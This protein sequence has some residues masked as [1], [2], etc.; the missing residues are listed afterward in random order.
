MAVPFVDAGALEQRLPIAE[1]IDTLEAAFRD[2]DPG[3]APSAPTSR[4]RPDR[5]C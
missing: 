3:A 1:A 5:S 2:G 4:P